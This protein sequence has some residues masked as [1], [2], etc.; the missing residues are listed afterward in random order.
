MIL[1]RNLLQPLSGNKILIAFFCCTI[2]IFGFYSNVYAKDRIV[3]VALILPLN[4][5]KLDVES[6]LDQKSYDASNVGIDFYRG[7]KIAL[8]SL[9]KTGI[10]FNV[11]VYDSESD[12][13]ALM[14]ILSD[15]FMLDADIIFAP[16]NVSE[17]SI[18]TNNL[19]N[20]RALIV[21]S[22]APQFNPAW[23]NKNI[24]VANNTLDQHAAYMADYLVNSIKATQFLIVRQGLLTET[25][26]SIPF[27]NNLD[28]TKHKLK[29]KEILISKS[30]FGNIEYSLSTSK[31][32][33]LIIPSSDQALAINLFKYLFP[34][35][36]YSVIEGT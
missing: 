13:I 21:S 24:V 9:S 28:T 29:F 27:K 2:G 25:K 4:F 15:P 3:N 12:S 23:K 33:Y 18:I 7:I 34:S 6:V 5:H 31:E 17:I 35:L 20:K 36:G 11:K 19:R 32:N 8:D 22:I 1:V 14:R 26:Y 30:G 16:L 10:K